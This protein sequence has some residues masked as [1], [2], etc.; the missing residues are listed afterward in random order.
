MSIAHL[1]TTTV[2][3]ETH[4]IFLNY[5]FV[6]LRKDILF[7]IMKG[8][9]ELKNLVKYIGLNHIILKGCNIRVYKNHYTYYNKRVVV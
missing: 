2:R 4:K 8:L 7:T 9:L 5:D 3:D 1:K 6:I